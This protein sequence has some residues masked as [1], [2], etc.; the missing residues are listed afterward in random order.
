MPAGTVLCATVAAALVAVVIVIICDRLAAR[1]NKFNIDTSKLEEETIA[2]A[3]KPLTSTSVRVDLPRFCYKISVYGP[4][5]ECVFNGAT[6]TTQSVSSATPPTVSAI[7]P[8]A[9][10]ASA[11][12]STSLRSEE[13]TR[14]LI[15]SLVNL[16]I[17]LPRRDSVVDSVNNSYK[18]HFAYMFTEPDKAV[19]PAQFLHAYLARALGADS[20][21]VLL[22]K[23]CTQEF[24]FPT[25]H[26]LKEKFGLQ[27]P[28]QDVHRGWHILIRD[29]GDKITVAHSK[30]EQGKEPFLAAFK[31]T[32]GVSLSF[33][34][35]LMF[36]PEGEPDLAAAIDAAQFSFNLSALTFA[37][38]CPADVAES[39]RAYLE[40]FLM[41]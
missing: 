28:Y 11:S 18:I 1:R 31:F 7:V 3:T 26:L 38:D 13:C 20:P 34:K 17:P 16:L 33:P 9:S 12:T 24:I 35:Q 39:V 25:V 27:H 22:L 37:T 8:E 40:P 30:Q 32:W 4:E 2:I 15:V 41:H 21:L 5:N 10:I 23:C 6:Q 29:T 14:R 19:D 36:P